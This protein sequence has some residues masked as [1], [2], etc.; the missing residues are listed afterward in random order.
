MFV[1]CVRKDEQ[2]NI[3]LGWE[4][5]PDLHYGLLPL[6]HQDKSYNHLLII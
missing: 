4:L 6:D 1:H 2:Q 5:N 3:D